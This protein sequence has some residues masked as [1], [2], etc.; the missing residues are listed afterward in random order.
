MPAN[1]EDAVQFALD[2]T[3]KPYCLHRPIETYAPCYDCSA[4]VV[5]SLR[6][7]GVNVPANI[8][9]TVDLYKWGLQ[10][11]GL[12]SVD[13]GVRVRGSIMLKGRWWGFGNKGHT[14]ISLGNG[15]EMAAHGFRSGIHPSDIYGGRNYEDGLI[16]PGV[17]YPA[18]DP[19]VDPDV[20]AALVKLVAWKDRICSESTA[21]GTHGPLEQGMTNG[22]V[23][24]LGDLLI[25]RGLMAR[26]WKANTYHR[27]M[28]DAVVHFKKLEGLSNTVGHTFGCEAATAILRPN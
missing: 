2:Q 21:D 3:G 16:I 19:P 14:S 1:I 13:K 26:K 27:Y 28:R 15:T 18:L 11:G 4:L 17:R 25:A 8:G 10:I 9:N 5:A 7:A 12:V 23:S 22:N 6:H 24:I 20:L